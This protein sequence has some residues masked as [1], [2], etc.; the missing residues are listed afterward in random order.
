MP[1]QKEKERY[2]YEDWLSWDEDFRAELIDGDVYM[3]A[4]P[5]R[6]HQAVIMEISRQLANFLKDKPCKVFPAPFGVRLSEYEDTVFE[7][8]IVVVC[9]KSKLDD[10]GC[11]GAPDLIVEILSP[12]SARMDKLLKYN[13]YQQSGVREYWIVDPDTTSVQAAILDNG[14]YYMTVYGEED[15]APVVVLPGC[16]I[17]LKDVFAEL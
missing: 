9:D 3:M 14:R 10:K 1:L 15:V 6:R 17:V 12:S 13:K 16:E 4:P 2:T 8:D 11:N 5:S 7:P